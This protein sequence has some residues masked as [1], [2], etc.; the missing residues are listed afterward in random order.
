MSPSRVSVAARIMPKSSRTA[1]LLHDFSKTTP[2]STP[3]APDRKKS[4][5]KPVLGKL[6]HPYKP[7][8]LAATSGR[9][10]PYFSL[11][12]SSV[13]VCFLSQSPRTIRSPLFFGHSY[14]SN[15][16]RVTLLRRLG[17]SCAHELRNH[18]RDVELPE[19]RFEGD[20]YGGVAGG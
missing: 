16:G 9:R 1:A 3:R 17:E 12:A 5:R 11:A 18:D 13:K 4:A 15:L 7:Q 6:S 8:N 10:C 14:C 2:R 19:Q 20:Q